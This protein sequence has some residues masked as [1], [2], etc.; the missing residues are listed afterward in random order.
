MQIKPD[1]DNLPSLLATVV[2]WLEV[3]PA[4]R[5]RGLLP[6]GVQGLRCRFLGFFFSSSLHYSIKL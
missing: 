3:N 4:G 6:V 1:P 5:G 2:L